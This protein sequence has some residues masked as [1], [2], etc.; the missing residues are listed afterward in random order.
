MNVIKCLV[1][2]FF[3]CLCFFSC[4]EKQVEL[5]DYV[6]NFDHNMVKIY[7]YSDGRI[8]RERTV[9]SV[10]KAYSLISD[11]LKSNSRGWEKSYL[12]YAPVLL[13]QAGHVSL[14]QSGDRYVIVYKS[15]DEKFIQLEKSVQGGQG[16]DPEQKKI[17]IHLLDL[18]LK[19]M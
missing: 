17:D 3:L 14:N 7:L 2:Y 5:P 10:D 9:S 1:Q 6:V 18:I 19:E 15:G 8:V 11:W 13:V 4:S 12:N 16:V